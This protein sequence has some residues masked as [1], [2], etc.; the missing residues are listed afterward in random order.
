[1]STPLYSIFVRERAESRLTI[2]VSSFHARE[3]LP[4]PA[5]PTFFF[6]IL[7]DENYAGSLLELEVGA[8][9]FHEVWLA[10]HAGAYVNEVTL[11]E[12]TD[13]PPQTAEGDALPSA[14]YHITVSHPNW[15][16]HLH[17]GA[18]WETAAYQISPLRSVAGSRRQWEE[19]EHTLKDAWEGKNGKTFPVKDDIVQ[20]LIAALDDPDTWHVTEAIQWLERIEGADTAVPRLLQALDDRMHEV[21]FAALFALGAIKDRRAVASLLCHLR[22]CTQEERWGCQDENE[23]ALFALARLGPQAALA[24]D[25]VAR[26]AVSTNGYQRMVSFLALYQITGQETY[27]DQFLLSSRGQNSWF[28]L[29]ELVNELSTAALLK[30]L[31]AL[32]EE[33]ERRGLEG[34]ILGDSE[35]ICLGLMRLGPQAAEARPVLHR[36]MTQKQSYQDEYTEDAIA[37]AMEM[38]ERTLFTVSEVHLPKQSDGASGS[39]QM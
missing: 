34:L 20:H 14:V 2:S 8:H 25:A 6:S 32:L 18:S 9:P 12:I 21:R 37:E 22:Y 17:Q 13:Y 30:L 15:I 35:P 7:F 39:G 4:N 19:V 31:P 24:V 16:A 23:A 29:T 5:N 26:R 38:L 33:L 11:L 27:L 1:M 28:Y 10:E 36:L 3:A